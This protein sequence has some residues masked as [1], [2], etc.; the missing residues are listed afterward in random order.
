MRR[1]K[2]SNSRLFALVDDADYELLSKFNWCVRYSKSGKPYPQTT[3]HFGKSQ[4]VFTMHQM[5][6]DYPLA[7]HKDRNGLN[8]QRGNL[9]SATC[10]QNAWNSGVRKN[11]KSGFKGVVFDKARKKWSAKINANG[12]RFYVGRFETKEDAATAYNIAA[13]KFHGEFAYQNKIPK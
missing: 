6:V 11:N 8:N 1:I 10:A 3:V 13:K 2:L 12:K 5:L 4:R 7:D 9:R